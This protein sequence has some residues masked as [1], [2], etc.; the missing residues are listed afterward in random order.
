MP[1]FAAPAVRLLLLGASAMLTG[2]AL[3]LRRWSRTF[4]SSGAGCATYLLAAA[5]LQVGCG[6]ARTSND[7]AGAD[8]GSA[9]DASTDLG[10]IDAGVD[11]LGV[12]ASLGDAPT[13]RHRVD[14]PASALARE[15]LR[16]MGATEAGGANSCHDCHGITRDSIRHFR[17]LSDTAW[18]TCFADL[19]V[20]TPAAAERVI[21]C[22]R[23]AGNY[24]A[25]K[26]GIYSTGAYF[27]WFRYVFQRARGDA[28]EADYDAFVARVGMSPRGHTT[29]TQAEFDLV[30]EWFLR[31]TP[32]VDTV[33]PPPSPPPDCVPSVGPEVARIV[34]DGALT[35]WAARNTE[36]SI[37]M[38]GCA[39]A[40][41]PEECLSTYPLAS[42]RAIGAGWSV[43]SGST[44]RVLFEMNYRSSYWTR[45]S[46]DGRFVAHG[47]S[48]D[49]SGAA[50]IDLQRGIVIGAEAS[51]DPGFF[52]DNSG[53]LFQ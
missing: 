46:A 51:F 36:A 13:L 15:A 45:S 21:S 3:T 48:P 11:D 50:F 12:D 28:W 32:Q 24:S 41:T 30:T 34:A 43:V 25:G 22:F 19:A 26:L 47:G 17:E 29:W 20:T 42:E 49:G 31:G 40:S 5:L 16:L 7:D 37:L 8:L 6:D 1:A 35:G 14:M 33:L 39:G 27:D 38:H 23:D 10:R 4:A 53:F 44:A 18:S 2:V 52:P 9:P